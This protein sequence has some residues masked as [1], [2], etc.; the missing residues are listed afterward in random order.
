MKKVWFAIALAAF[1]VT[2]AVL[3]GGCEN[4][5][6]NGTTTVEHHFSD[7]V[8]SHHSVHSLSVCLLNVLYT[9]G[10]SE[11]KECIIKELNI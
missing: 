9:Q 5:Q 1:A 3:L 6:N 11:P 8:K 4:R 2:S 10:S 7:E